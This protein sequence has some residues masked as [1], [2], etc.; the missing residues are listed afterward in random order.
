MPPKPPQKSSAY[1]A[2]NNSKREYRAKNGVVI[3]RRAWEDIRARESGFKN[4]AHWQDLRKDKL[5]IRMMREA[6]TN[7][8]MAYK[9]IR[10]VTSEFNQTFAPAQRGF[11]LHHRIKDIRETAKNGKGN[12]KILARTE[13]K[14]YEAIYE[15]ANGPVAEFLTYTGLRSASASYDVG[16]SP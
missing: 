11:D 5:Y 15:S 7:K 2:V 6:I 16:D 4:W 8:G 9:N 3:S 10:P 14:E 1:T 12:A 13:L